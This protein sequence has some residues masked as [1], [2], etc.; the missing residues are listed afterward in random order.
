MAPK[1]HRPLGMLACTHVQMHQNSGC[2]SATC[3]VVL[4]GPASRYD[5]DLAAAAATSAYGS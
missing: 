5:S 3:Y 4:D 1:A 2:T